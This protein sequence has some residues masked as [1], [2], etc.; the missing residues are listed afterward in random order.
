MG[1]GC[2]VALS[3]WSPQSDSRCPN[4]R[5]KL[6]GYDLS[7]FNYIQQDSFLPVLVFTICHLH[8]SICVKEVYMKCQIESMAPNE[9]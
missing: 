4:Y 5:Y 6:T 3:A 2:Q 7:M 9:A 1:E 8:P